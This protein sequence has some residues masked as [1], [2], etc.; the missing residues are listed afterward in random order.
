M[1]KKDGRRNN[2]GARP[3]SG[4]KPFLHNP[5]KKLVNLD[6]ETI[7]IMSELGGGNLS[8]GIRKAAD[9]LRGPN[10]KVIIPREDISEMIR[11]S[12]TKESS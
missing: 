10:I 7:A 9:I 3:G 11:R 12:I 5:S 4:P 6:A 1:K 8:A 2:G